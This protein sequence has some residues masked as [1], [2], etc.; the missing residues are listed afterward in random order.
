MIPGIISNLTQVSRSVVIKQCVT[1]T[2]ENDSEF[3]SVW[4]VENKSLNFK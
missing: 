2:R 4:K 1:E 3:V